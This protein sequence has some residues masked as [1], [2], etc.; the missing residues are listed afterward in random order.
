MDLSTGTDYDLRQGFS[1]KF[2][3][4]RVAV[5]RGIM[6]RK[7]EWRVAREFVNFL[8]TDL[9]WSGIFVEIWSSDGCMSCWKRNNEKNELPANSWNWLW[10]LSGIFIEILNTRGNGYTSCWSWKIVCVWMSIWKRNNEK[11]EWRV[12]CGFVDLLGTDYDHRQGFSLKF[13]IRGGAM[14]VYVGVER[15]IRRIACEF[16]DPLGSDY[17]HCQG[18]WLKFGY[19]DERL[20]VSEWYMKEKQWEKWLEN[21]L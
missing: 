11:N 2:W 8:R 10:L 14:N 15:G 21:R 1:L 5:E 9:F 16:M 4:R 7:M 20:F 6:R 3:I 12:A 13:R 17:D 19:G 18:F